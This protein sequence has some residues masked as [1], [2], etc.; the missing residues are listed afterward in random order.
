MPIEVI[1][2][3]RYDLFRNSEIPKYIDEL[4]DKINT[5]KTSI[6]TICTQIES[7]SAD[8][9]HHSKEKMMILTVSLNTVT[10]SQYF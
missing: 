9:S 5:V 4:T 7:I 3:E 6:E 1:N 10:F 2:D 8:K